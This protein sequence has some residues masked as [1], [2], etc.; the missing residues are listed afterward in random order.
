MNVNRTLPDPRPPLV[1]IAGPTA[2]GKTSVS[3]QLAKR[4]QGSVI[5]ADSMQVYRGMD[6][7][8]AKIL[9][10]EMQGIPHYLIDIAE[11]EEGWNVV[12]F[13]REAG[14]VA[15]E[16]LAQGRLPFLVGGTGFYIQA[17]LYGIDFTE[18]DADTECRSRL[19]E[20]VRLQGPESLYRRL[21]EIDPA[22]AETIHPNNVKRIIRAL[23][24]TMK[25][26]RQISEH[27]RQEHL[28]APVYNAVF[29]V[30][31]MDR[32]RLYERIDLRV[33][34]MIRDGLVE[35]VRRL[36]ERGLTVED[37]AMQGIGYRQVLRALDGE[38]SM[39]EAVRLIKRDSRHFAKR[40]LTWFRRERDVQWIDLDAF[41]DQQAL[42]QYMEETIRTKLPDR[43]E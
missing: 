17:L 29:F 3:V 34:R 7:G 30:L 16:I 21:Q 37:V 9:K 13:Q 43:T 8:S 35:E 31:N 2:T 23:E 10:D 14:A 36:R 26:G 27:N 25:S 12:R 5:S 39:E 41:P 33:D 4:L 19:E 1:I 11:P 42:L 40:Q 15:D 18:M 22:S 24:F 6:I 20:E 38:Y 32:L 28:R